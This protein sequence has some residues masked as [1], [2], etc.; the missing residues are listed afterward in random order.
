MPALKFPYM[1]GSSQGAKGSF[2][3]QKRFLVGVGV[4]FLCFCILFA[5]LIYFHE[6][7]MLEEAAHVKSRIVMAA[8]E[9]TR[10]YV[11]DTLRPTMYEVLG[12]DAFVLEAMSTS[13]VGRSVMERFREYLPDYQYRR[14]APHPRNPDS[15]PKPF[16][17]HIIDYFAKNPARETWQGIISFQGRTHFLHARPVYFKES[18]MHC[19]GDPD[20]A[21]ASLVE[22]YGAERGF[23]HTPGEIAGLNAVDIPVDIALAKIKERAYSLF[24]VS[25]L[26]LTLLY[27][28]I[29]FFF[30]RVVVHSLRDLLEIF[31]HGLVSEEEVQLLREAKAKDEISELR[32]GAQVMTDHL[33]TAR[34]QL[35]EYAQNL[36]HMVQ[37]RTK[38]LRESQR[39]LK[40]KVVTRNRELKGLTTIAE[41]ITQSDNLADILPKVLEQT[42]VLIPCRGG[43][44]YLLREDPA[45]LELQCH[46]N[47]GHLIP[48]VA[49]DDTVEAPLGQEEADLASSMQGA[50]HGRMSLFTC[51]EHRSCLNVPLICREK[52]LG[53]MTF[54]GVDFKELSFDMKG[55]LLSIGQQAGITIESLQNIEKIIQSKNLLQSV[56]DGITDMLVLLDRDFNIR[57]VN[58]AQTRRFGASFP[59]GSIP[60]CKDPNT[61][62]ACPFVECGMENA[63]STRRP[64]SEE[65]QGKDGSIF[66]VN[67]YPILD[68][69]GEV[70][71]VVRYAKDITQSKRVEQKI[72]HTEKLVA[73]GQLSAGIAHE[74]N[75][76]IGVILCYTD[77]LKHQLTDQAQGLKDVG[78]IEKHAHNCQRI[79]SDLLNFAR[80]QETARLPTPL[81]EALLEVVHIIGHQFQRKRRKIELDLDPHLPLVP[82][83]V[84]KIKQVILNLLMNA[85]QAMGPK[86]IIRIGTRHLEADGTVRITVWDNGEGVPPE[87]KD[88]V[89]DPFFSTKDIGEGSGLGL[90]V[91][92]A[93]IRNHGGEILLDSEPG[94]WTCFTILLP[95]SDEGT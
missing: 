18:C 77:L 24:G 30:N 1:P 3:L 67:Y 94:R 92:Y 28:L 55:L 39:R 52:V 50:A 81:N 45:S 49:L 26:C 37:T 56:F 42:L 95:L 4:I 64:Y 2:S 21:P 69:A 25:F 74:L 43:A 53:V 13:Y 63:F 86:G 82:I 7:N 9:A 20:E 15:E 54:V 58:K 41:L 16:E 31:R 73:L 19:H 36:E 14:V 84:D 68:D 33:R 83:D 51:E 48:R 46:V 60:R 72:Q 27:A 32:A 35:E 23:H 70:E 91:S 85:H 65:V 89:F 78:T 11:R 66:L 57:M 79:V 5:L 47:A 62:D 87:I 44:F 34:Q 88:R 90:S 12:K 6:K 61:C 80:G 38:A 75:N 71:S 40:D 17:K 8:V 59:D 93:I 22:L 76:P 29:C 10:S